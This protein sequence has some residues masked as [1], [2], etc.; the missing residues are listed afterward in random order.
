[1]KWIIKK[2]PKFEVGNHVRTSKYKNIFSK[3]YVPNWSEKGFVITKVK[4][5]MLWTYVISDLSGGQV[6]ETFY[7]KEL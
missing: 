7:E 5:T 3:G 1:M 4:N 2:D 6:V